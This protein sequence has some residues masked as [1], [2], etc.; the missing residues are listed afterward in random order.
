[1]AWA[2][3]N[4]V[5][6]RLRFLAQARRCDKS[7][8]ELCLEYGVSRKTG[9]KLLK[10]YAA[11]GPDGLRDRSRA[12][13]SHPNQTPPEIEAAILR[14]RKQHPTWGSKKILAVLE[15]SAP[16]DAWPAR[17]TID[18]VLKRAGLVSPRG[19]TR[20]RVERSKPF[21][22]PTRP[23]E[24]WTMDYKGH[25]RVGDG[26]RCDPLTVNDA[27]SRCSLLCKGMVQPRLEGVR[28]Q[29]E[30]C[31]LQ[32]G[33]PE[34]ILSDNGPPFAS[35][36]LGGLS[37][38]GVWLLRLG[39]KPVFIQ[40]GH[41]EQNGR[42]ERFHATLKRETAS[43]PKGSIAAQQRAF[44]DFQVV[45][46]EERPHEALGMDVPAAHY[47]FSTREM[48][49]KLADPE[50]QPGIEV[51]RVRRDGS[52][53]WRSRMVFVGEALG[54]ELVGVEPVEDGVQRVSFAGHVLGVLHERSGTIAPL[55]AGGVTHVPGH[56]GAARDE[57]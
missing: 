37:R 43:P 26:T 12:P 2:E 21:V 48:P 6:E 29:L 18:A 55:P 7:M 3:T 44:N 46:N 30:G 14:V 11:E 25:F 31:F 56:G 5:D 41:P 4:P 24:F 35:R 20:R 28:K 38:L 51:R 1:M 39:V 32:F 22:E 49:A 52:M 10:R 40:P 19:R 57:A 53:K 47:D 36:G 9:Y 16:D 45:Y 34:A 27:F 17:S 23:N 15:T 42:H 54:G 50:Y 13:R 8:V 33:L